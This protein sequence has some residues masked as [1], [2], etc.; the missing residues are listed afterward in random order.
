M[1]F[2]RDTT[3][4]EDAAKFRTG[5]GA[6]DRAVFHSFAFNQLRVAGHTKACV[7]QPSCPAG[8]WT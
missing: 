5:P 8:D 3:F 7:C 6:D 4:T 1:H 2:F